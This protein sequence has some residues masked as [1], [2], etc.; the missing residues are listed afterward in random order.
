M[1]YFIGLTFHPESIHFQKI[2]F[3][4]SRYDNK[5]ARSKVLQMTILPPFQLNGTSYEREKIIE[6]IQDEIENQFLG[7]DSPLDVQ[8]KG[9]EFLTGKR[10]ALFLNPQ[11]PIELFHCQETIREIFKHNNVS[12][13]KKKDSQEK[14]SDNL[15]TYLPIGRFQY[16]TELEGAIE[17][18]QLEFNRPFT[19]AGNKLVLFEKLPLQWVVRHVFLDFGGFDQWYDTHPEKIS[20][21]L[22]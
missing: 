18:A 9:I 20:S 11:L 5:F 13:I 21:S 16:F 15:K 6:L 22:E 4:R 1:T 8:F 14:N 17:Q 7:L 3:F 10:P 12:F 19:M 2:N